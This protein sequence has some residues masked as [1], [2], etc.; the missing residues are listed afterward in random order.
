MS[1]EHT[2]P[3]SRVHVL[4]AGAIGLLVAAHLRQLGHPITLLLRS[5]TAVD[6]FVSKGSRV[7][8]FNDWIR[9]HPTRK[10]LLQQEAQDPIE[11]WVSND[12]QAELP[13]T[14][15]VSNQSGDFARIRQLLITTKAHD[16]VQAYWSVK[17]RLDAQSTVVL[18]QNGMG[19]YEAIQREFYSP[20]GQHGQKDKEAAEPPSFVVGTNSHGCLRIPGEHFATHHTAMAELKFAVR[21][22]LH[23]PPSKLPQSTVDVLSALGSMQLQ[24]SIVSWSE[25]HHQM[26]LK[27]AANAVINPITAL[28]DCRNGYL[29]PQLHES[30]MRCVSSGYYDSMKSLVSSAC[31]EIASIYARAHPH[32]QNELTAHALEKYVAGVASAT[33][34]N[35]SSMLQDVAAGMQT[36]IDWINGYLIRLGKQHGVPTPVNTLLYTLIKLKEAGRHH[37]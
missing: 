36:E 5:Q 26:L 23:N 14:N 29:A 27:L 32:L 16:T 20:P 31:A 21:A 13:Q 15:S 37:P 24:V 9:T 30:D 33:A 28:T 8:V 2:R 34:R 22:S 25:L 12:I 35:R 3:L 11:P 1:L 17:N 18:L 10:L 7:A 19:T 4:G 6:Q